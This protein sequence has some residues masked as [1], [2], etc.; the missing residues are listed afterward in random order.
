MNKEKE[1][2][3]LGY[4]QNLPEPWSIINDKYSVGQIVKGRAVQIKD[5]GVFVE[6]E[7]GLDGLV[8]ISEIAYKRVNNI[9]DEITVGQ[10]ITAKILDIDQNR[11]R[12]SLSVKDTQMKPDDGTSSS[13]GGGESRSTDGARAS[14]TNAGFAPTIGDAVKEALAEAAE[15]AREKAEA[16]EEGV[17]EGAGAVAEKVLDVIETVSEKTEE[18]AEAFIEKVEEITA[19]ADQDVK[20]G[21][22]IETVPSGQTGSYE[23]PADDAD[24]GEGGIAGEEEAYGASTPAEEEAAPSGEEPAAEETAGTDEAADEAEAPVEEA[25]STSEEEPPAEEEDAGSEEEKEL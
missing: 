11:R 14:S 23:V 25:A 2:I 7:P 18:A 1:K 24:S 10:D 13:S 8:H 19:E 9:S 21:V 12:I 6:L 16:I 17:R 5:Y 3:S 22:E 4:K 20:L 15:A